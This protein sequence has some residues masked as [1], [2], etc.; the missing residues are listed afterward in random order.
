LGFLAGKFVVPDPAT[1]SELGK[2]E[3]GKMFGEDD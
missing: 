1:F 2:D 3:I